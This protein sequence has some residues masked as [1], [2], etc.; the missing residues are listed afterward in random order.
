MTI[1]QTVNITIY[2][3]KYKAMSWMTGIIHESMTLILDTCRLYHTGK[4]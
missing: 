4:L 3:V 2:I 1:T